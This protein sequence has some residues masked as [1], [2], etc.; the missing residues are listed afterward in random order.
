[1]YAETGEREEKHTF[2][3]LRFHTPCMDAATESLADERADKIHKN[4]SA[5]KESTK[6]T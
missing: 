2:L 5:S 4:Q 1:M 3:D 6:K